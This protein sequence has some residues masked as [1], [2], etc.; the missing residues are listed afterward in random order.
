MNNQNKNLENPSKEYQEGKKKLEITIYLSDMNSLTEK[1]LADRL[2]VMS[3]K[4]DNEVLSTIYKSL[5]NTVTNLEESE[6]LQA[7]SFVSCLDSSQ[8]CTVV[9]Y[10]CG[11]YGCASNYGRVEYYCSSGNYATCERCY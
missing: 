6:E 9:Y 11:M 5:A 1:S 2:T 7:K 4:A 10:A 3:K 8:S